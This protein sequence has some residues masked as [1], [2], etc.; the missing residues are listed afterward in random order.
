MRGRAWRDAGSSLPELLAAASLVMVA[1]SL[2]GSSLLPTLGALGTVAEVDPVAHELDIAADT[3]VRLVRSA[4]RGPDGPAASGVSGGVALRVPADDE[5]V[6]VTVRVVDGSVRLSGGP[7]GDL[8][9]DEVIARPGGVLVGGLDA[10]TEVAGLQVGSEDLVVAVRVRLIADG[11][12]A[13][14]VV[15]VEGSR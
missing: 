12:E 7:T 10:G 5:D 6:T 3:I 1:L 11:H 13:V 8:T 9:W 15:R 2:L 4:R 14:R